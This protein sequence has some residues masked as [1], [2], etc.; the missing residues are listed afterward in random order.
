MTSR[1]EE[2]ADGNETEGRGPLAVRWWTRGVD[3]MAAIGTLMIVV[4]MAMIC[5][6]VVARNA[7][8]GSLPLISE[9]GALT[10][11]IIV[12]MQLGTTVRNERLAGTDFFLIALGERMPRAAAFVSGLWS[13]V[14]LAVCAG[15]AYSTWDI[16]GR[17]IEHRDYIGVTGIATLPTWPF[18]VLVLLG[19]AVAA[20]QFLFQAIGYFGKAAGRGE[21]RA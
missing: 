3:G 21:R 11:V 20:I 16:V 18:R 2:H 4:L 14:G 9:L 6:D 5:A 19:I 12:Y 7:F 8:G 17:A 10:V 15:I 13:L 1:S